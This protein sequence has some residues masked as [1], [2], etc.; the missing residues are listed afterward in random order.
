MYTKANYTLNE[1]NKMKT[2]HETSFRGKQPVYLRNQGW[3][4]GACTK[5]EDLLL[6]VGYLGNDLIRSSNF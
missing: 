5:A 1:I 6:L 4:G 2:E 3:P